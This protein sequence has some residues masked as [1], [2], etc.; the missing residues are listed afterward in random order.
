[1]GRWGIGANLF[2]LHGA[3]FGLAAKLE[4]PWELPAPLQDYL[5]PS[6]LKGG[7]GRP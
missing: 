2:G 5:Q 1:M 6:R 7:Q 4:M 3:L